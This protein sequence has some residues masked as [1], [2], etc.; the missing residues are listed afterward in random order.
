METERGEQKEGGKKK[1]ERKRNKDL[2][3][4]AI[5]CR[6]EH[7]V[8]GSG[9]DENVARTR[10]KHR[11]HVASADARPAKESPK[12]KNVTKHKKEKTKNKKKKKKKKENKKRKKLTETTLRKLPCRTR[13][14]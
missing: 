5:A 12:Q 13:C 3:E 11:R 2:L 1:K 14:M 9:V 6:D 4:K 10:R 8:V 7:E